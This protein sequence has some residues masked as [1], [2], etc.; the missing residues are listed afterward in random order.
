MCLFSSYIVR[1]RL[2]VNKYLWILL[3]GFV[4]L[5]VGCKESAPPDALPPEAEIEENEDVGQTPEDVE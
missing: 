5:T 1:W 3:L 4:V 2:F